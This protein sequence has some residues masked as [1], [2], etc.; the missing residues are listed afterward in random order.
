MYL[1]RTFVQ[2]VWY[3]KYYVRSKSLSYLN[4]KDVMKAPTFYVAILG[5]PWIH[6]DPEAIFTVQFL[7]DF[8]WF[9]LCRIEKHYVITPQNWF[10]NA[11]STLL[12]VLWQLKSEVALG[13]RWKP[14]SKTVHIAHQDQVATRIEHFWQW[15]PQLLSY[16]LWRDI[17]F[18]IITHSFLAGVCWGPC[19]P[20]KWEAD[21]WG[22]LEVRR[23]AIYFTSQWTSVC[24]ELAD[25]MVTLQ[26][27]GGTWGWLGVE[28]WQLCLQDTSRSAKCHWWAAVG[29]WVPLCVCAVL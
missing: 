20:S 16:V 24:T 7:T 12:P 4:L 19:N 21:I 1:F 8:S 3:Y 18:C 11:L 2:F 29:H 5:S 17:S 25:S 22:W 13:G 6:Y 27:T 28:K 15:N 14:R 23:S 9:L 10:W 26:C